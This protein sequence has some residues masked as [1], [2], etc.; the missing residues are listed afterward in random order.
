MIRQW[1]PLA[2]VLSAVVVSGCASTKHWSKP[3]VTQAE[4]ARDSF[5]CATK[6][7]GKDGSVSK[8]VYRACMQMFGYERRADGKFE[9]I[10]D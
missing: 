10:G 2:W 5:E 4:F 6:S 7:P 3:G 8:D 9:G 1:L